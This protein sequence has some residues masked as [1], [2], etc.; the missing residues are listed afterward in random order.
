MDF[1]QGA[2]ISMTFGNYTQCVQERNTKHHWKNTT[3]RVSNQQPVHLSLRSRVQAAVLHSVALP[4][5]ATLLATSRVPINST[6]C[7]WPL[8]THA[9]ECR[10]LSDMTAATGEH[11]AGRGHGGS[12]PAI[13]FSQPDP[14][15]L[16]QRFGSMDLLQ[17]RKEGG[18]MGDV[19]VLHH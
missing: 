14:L 17:A 5:P 4:L 2:I 1:N 19:G 10:C 3:S 8:L 12:S 16:E 11:T 15:L 13:R 7:A 6:L 9:A 18:R